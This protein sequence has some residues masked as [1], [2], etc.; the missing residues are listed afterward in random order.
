MTILIGQKLVVGD[1]TFVVLKQTR[2]RMELRRAETALHAER[3]R[4]GLNQ[5]QMAARFGISQSQY[6]RIEVGFA[7]CPPDYLATAQAMK[8]GIGGCGEAA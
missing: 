8:T 4:L 2:N 1:D 7:P 6:C 5:Q 3:L